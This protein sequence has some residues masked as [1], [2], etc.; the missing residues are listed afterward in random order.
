MTAT[1][2]HSN[3]FEP[4]GISYRLQ[5]A[6]SL[7]RTLRPRLDPEK[8]VDS[9]DRTETGLL[10]NEAKR[11]PRPARSATGW[12]GKEN[13]RRQEATQRAEAAAQQREEARR[14]AEL[15]AA[16]PCPV[17]S[18]GEDPVHHELPPW[19]L[20]GRV[21]QSSISRDGTVRYTFEDGTTETY[22][23]DRRGDV[24]DHGGNLV[25]PTR[26]APALLLPSAASA[27]GSDSISAAEATQAAATQTRAELDRSFME[28]GLTR[29]GAGGDSQ[30]GLL[31]STPPPETV[32]QETGPAVDPVPVNDDSGRV[33]SPTA[34]ETAATAPE[35]G[36]LADL[37]ADARTKIAL[38]DELAGKARTAYEGALLA[39]VPEF[40]LRDGRGVKAGGREYVLEDL[41][42]DELAGEY[43]HGRDATAGFTIDFDPEQGEGPAAHYSTK[44]AAPT[45]FGSTFTPRSARYGSWDR[46]SPKP[47]QRS[48]RNRMLVSRSTPPPPSG[49][50]TRKPR[51]TT[52]TASSW[53]T[54]ASGTSVFA[55]TPHRKRP[56]SPSS[57]RSTLSSGKPRPP[58]RATPS[59]PGRRLSP[60]PPP[61]ANWRWMPGRTRRRLQPPP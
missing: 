17:R 40:Y 48:R 43:I 25:E 26:Q 14:Q 36:S 15:R 9:G 11:K 58:A 47:P 35:N 56:K 27:G 52:R 29:T 5:P 21:I 7:R 44:E 22:D 32:P 19:T 3:R 18:G 61:P 60:T 55:P 39:F 1:I 24:R 34:I 10:E 54:P 41:T 31:E 4:P 2:E 6:G 13:R 45:P 42:P 8:A 16:N 57:T 37:E 51:R 23:R 28:D 59:P 46:T 49:R 12:S 30:L 50:H 53:R 33:I 38:S 20:D